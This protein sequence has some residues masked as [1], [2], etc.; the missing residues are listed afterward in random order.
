MIRPG[1]SRAGQLWIP[2]VV[3]TLCSVVSLAGNTSL[4][5]PPRFD[6]AGYAM[7]AEALATGEG[8]RDVALPEPT[9]HTHFPPGY[10]AALALLWSITG[11]S[12]AAAHLFSCACTVAATLSAWLWFRCLYPP[13]VA[14]ILGLALAMNWTWGRYGGAILSE[15]MFLL[16]AQ[17]ALLATV[18]AGQ[19]GG[20]I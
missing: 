4:R 17:L 8:Y 20:I 10:P 12:S 14:F 13:R 19:R 11:R 3:I 16:L 5:E 6:G 2:A 9:R 7:L 1:W 18:H 15:P